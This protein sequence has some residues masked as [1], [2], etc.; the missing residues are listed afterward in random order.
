MLRILGCAV[1]IAMVI[2]A[3][4][5][6]HVAAQVNP[7]RNTAVEN[8]TEKDLETIGAAAVPLYTIA[9]PELG[10]SATWSNPESGNF[11]T[12]ELVD[13]YEWRK[14][15]CRR[16]HHLMRVKGWKDTLN[17]TIERCQVSSGEWKIRY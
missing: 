6:N 12:I 8:L 1:A 5:A 11:G 15:P 2:I 9:N 17:L 4:P 16:L 13:I 14:M 10:S 3:V 7:F